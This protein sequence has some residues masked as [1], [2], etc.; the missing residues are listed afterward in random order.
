MSGRRIRRELTPLLCDCPPWS[1]ADFY[2]E[3]ASPEAD[4]EGADTRVDALSSSKYASQPAASSMGGPKAQNHE[5]EVLLLGEHPAIFA[6][7]AHV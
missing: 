7:L 1:R 5:V 6:P 2:Q 4:R 3:A